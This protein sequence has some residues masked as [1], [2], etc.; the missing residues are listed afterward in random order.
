MTTWKWDDFNQM[1]ATKNRFVSK[2]NADGICLLHAFKSCFL[3]DF[4]EIIPIKQIKEKV[5]HYLCENSGKYTG[6]H[7]ESPDALVDELQT[8]FLTQV[9]VTSEVCDFLI[10]VLADV[11]N[12]DIRLCQKHR[13]SENIQILDFISDTNTKGKEIW[14]KF[15]RDPKD[16]AG[17]HYDSLVLT[18]HAKLNVILNTS[19]G[20][21]P[22][23]AEPGTSAEGEESANE[24]GLDSTQEFDQ[25]QIEDPV[26]EGF[27]LKQ[28]TPFPMHLFSDVTPEEVDFL[29]PEINGLK[30]Y[31]IKCTTANYSARCSDRRWFQ[32]R[33]S[34]RVGFNGI[35]KIGKCAGSYV[36]QYN[37][38]S[39]L[40]TEG[41]KNEANFKYMYKHRV[42]ASCGV[43]A[44][45]LPCG[46]VKMLELSSTTGICTVYHLGDHTCNPKINRKEN[47]E[48]ISEQIKKFPTLTPKNLQV[49]CVKERID[50]GDVLGAKL[51][52]KKLADRHRIRNLRSQLVT[53]D[54]NTDVN[55]LAAV[56]TFKVACDKVDECY[57]YEMNDGRM[58]GENDFVFKTTRL[59][60]ELGLMMDQEF[61]PM[62]CLQT[63]DAYFDGAH[64]RVQG[65]ISLGLW[66]YYRS[67]CRLIKLASMEVRSESAENIATFFKLWNRV[68]IVVGD[69]EDTYFFNPRKIMVDNSGANYAGVRIV[70]GLEYMIDKMLSCQWHFMHNMEIL[71]QSITD[72]K[73]CDDFLELCQ[74]LLLSTTIVE[75]QLTAG[76]LGQLAEKYPFLRPKLNWWHVRRWHVFGAFRTGPT[77]A[78]VNLAEIGNKL[79]KTTGTNLS[80]LEAAK[81][82]V[83]TWILQDEEIQQHRSMKLLSTGRGPTDVDIAAK[84]RKKQENEAEGLAQIITNREALRVQLEAEENPEHFVPASKSSHK[85]PKD[86]KKGVEGQFLD[87]TS[88]GK[89]TGKGKGR[90]KGKSVRNKLPN[91]R[92]LAQKILLA[93]SVMQENGEKNESTTAS[94][95][96]PVQP[97]V[98]PP[99]KPV[100]TR[101]R[102]NFRQ[103]NVQP[104]EG[105][106]GYTPRRSTRQNN[107]PFVTT[108]KKRS[109]YLCLGCNKWIWK[110]NYPHP[111]DLL[112][113]LKAIRPFLNPKTQ[114]W[115]H[116]EKNGFFHLDI[117]CL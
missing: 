10:R 39:F 109:K 46:A 18:A 106:Q 82:D 13:V 30:M 72:E 84:E 22:L 58:N 2:V 50:A 28:G 32:M 94:S 115:V 60:A 35:R 21:H 24:Q 117:N 107:P 11:F 91:V 43:I 116:P 96:P 55:S 86:A 90:G 104:D 7:K 74:K 6:F 20:K 101:A 23:H 41:R 110:K 12:V 40:S 80:L 70:F 17:N 16:E 37:N 33:T 34:S 92:E 19:Q 93:E 67:M 31:K 68:L 111:R 36:C 99:Q 53:T 8:Y 62:N 102:R 3:H 112:F 5:T 83:A 114:E 14:M 89:G 9:H 103:E 52:G 59:S 105:P 100:N 88:K 81:K 45:Q 95:R 38:C 54:Q 29:P 113:T 97:A 87:E 65:F 71:A 48:F 25:S 4:G 79:W 51:V 64:S 49:H 73:E 98:T 76:M 66:L 108:F 44:E 15:Y 85:P 61:T 75:Y 69:K 42:C 56:A 57:I 78:G 77:H 47:D 26:Q 27:S 63:E 1:A